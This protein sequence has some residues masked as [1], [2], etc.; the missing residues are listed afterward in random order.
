MECLHRPVLQLI[1]EVDQHVAAGD[2]IKP[3]EGRI[4]DDAVHREGAQL[5]DL[6]PQ[7]IIVAFIDE[8]P[9]QA[10]GRNARHGS[11]VGGPS[12][13]P[14]RAIINIGA[15]NLDAVTAR[16][17]VVAHALAHKDGNGIDFLAGCAAGHPNAD[18][19]AGWL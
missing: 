8:P 12:G 3:R 10:L 6:R 13:D 14:D 11:P 18:W 1:V 4:L 9:F 15:E 5:A 19:L 17:M 7:T 16:A 2:Q